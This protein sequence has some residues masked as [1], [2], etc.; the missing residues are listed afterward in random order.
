LIQ[1]GRDYEERI[2][3]LEVRIDKLSKL[4]EKLLKEN[5]SYKEEQHLFEAR[6][7][8]KE[9]LLTLLFSQEQGIL[10]TLPRPI[11]FNSQDK[12]SNVQ[13]L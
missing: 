10:P 6:F 13:I 7:I 1:L 11:V 5:N 2:K 9:K 12:T 4:N 8:E 3:Q